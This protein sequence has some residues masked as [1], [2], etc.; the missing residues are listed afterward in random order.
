[1]REELSA[2][3]SSARVTDADVLV[4]GGGF[5]GTWGIDTSLLSLASKNATY[6]ISAKTNHGQ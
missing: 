6:S 4:V 5:A 3:K 2:L 1:M